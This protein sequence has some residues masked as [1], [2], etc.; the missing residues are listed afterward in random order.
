MPN[1]PRPALPWKTAGVMRVIISGAGVAGLTLAWWLA[2]GGCSVLIVEKAST[3]RDE[4]FLVDFFGSGYDI[5]ERM[6]L[7]PRLR[8][9]DL[10]V[11]C[12]SWIDKREREFANLHF[13]RFKR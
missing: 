4:G 11:A 3:L 2:R 5:A 6:H 10:R 9:L 7:L 12:V 8:S 13:D 1:R